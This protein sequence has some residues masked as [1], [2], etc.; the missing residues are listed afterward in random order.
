MRS[1]WRLCHEYGDFTMGGLRASLKPALGGKS[2]GFEY[3][4]SGEYRTLPMSEPVVVNNS[5]AYNAACLGAISP[6]AC[7]CSWIGSPR[8]S[9]RYSPTEAAAD[10]SRRAEFTPTQ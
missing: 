10:R 1:P 7:A 6:S 8:F 2:E 9:G 3:P 4:G 5:D